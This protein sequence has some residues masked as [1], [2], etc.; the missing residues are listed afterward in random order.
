MKRVH[1][2]SE[3]TEEGVVSMRVL[4]AGVA[5]MVALA[6]LAAALLSGC[7]LREGPSSEYGGTGAGLVEQAENLTDDQA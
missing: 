3:C 7:E 1:V 6:A 4:N 2:R 5:G